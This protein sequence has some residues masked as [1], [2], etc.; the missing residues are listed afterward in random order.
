MT[1]DE[2]IYPE[3]ERFNPDRFFTVDGKLNDDDIMLAFGLADHLD[4]CNI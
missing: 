1:R 2:S 3:P 4:V